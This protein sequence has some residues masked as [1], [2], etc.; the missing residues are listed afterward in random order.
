MDSGWTA[1]AVTCFSTPFVSRKAREISTMVL[2][3][4]VMVRR[5]LSV[6]RATTVL[7][8]FSR[9]ASSWK[10]AASCSATTTAMR[11]WDSLMASSVPSRPSYFF[12]TRSRS[13]IRPS[14]SS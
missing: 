4:Q 6:T 12:G 9:S 5:P 7:S 8:R 13:I 3:F 1:W 11:S 14:A 2:P 10:R